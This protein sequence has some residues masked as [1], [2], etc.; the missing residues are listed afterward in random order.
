MHGN[1]HPAY[2]PTQQSFQ[3]QGPPWI[4]WLGIGL[5]G[6][7]LLVVA[8][9]GMV[10]LGTWTRE[11]FSL[12]AAETIHKVGENGVQAPRLLEKI[13]PQYTEEASEAELQGTIVMS[14]EVH[15]D[16][17]AYNLRLERGLGM[18]LDEN[19]MEAVKQWKFQPAVKDGEPVAVS[20]KIEVNFKLK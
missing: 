11:T 3:K 13:E 9:V 8:G 20:A 2:S 18:G 10:V 6:V 4:L 14:V 1:Q 5:G 19:A 7:V 17:R 12:Q 16:G 15:P